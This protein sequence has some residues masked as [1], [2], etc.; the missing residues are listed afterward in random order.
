[1]ENLL[2]NLYNL[3]QKLKSI[4]IKYDDSNKKIYGSL[5]NGEY[6]KVN[7]YIEL[8]IYQYGKQTNI[9]N[10]FNNNYDFR[11]LYDILNRYSDHRIKRVKIYEENKEDKLFL[12]NYHLSDFD[13]DISEEQKEQFLKIYSL[14]LK[15]YKSISLLIV[16]LDR[17]EYS[18]GII[19][20]NMNDI[21]NLHNE[22]ILTFKEF[23]I[24]LE[25]S[26]T[27]MFLNDIVCLFNKH[28]KSLNDIPGSKNYYESLKNFNEL[29]N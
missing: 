22:F 16:K 20:Y 25:I 8:D 18:N 3:L 14:I 28:V 13:F 29:K 27:N 21:V 23:E 15:Y 9:F 12:E 5:D 26:Q 24:D 10:M 2:Y 4:I 1:M 11:C 17:F 6:L 7:K 19:N